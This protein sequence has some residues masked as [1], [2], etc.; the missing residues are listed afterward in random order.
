[1][2]DPEFFGPG[3]PFAGGPFGDL[4]RNLARLF[5]TQGPV[6]WEIARQMALWAATGG[7]PEGNVDPVARVRMEELIRVAEL[8]VAEATGLAVSSSG[9]LSVRA[10]T[11]SEWALRTLEAWKPQLEALATRMNSA[12]A[13]SGEIGDTGG[14][15]GGTE[16]PAGGEDPMAKLFA[17]L[18]QVLGPF[19]F[20]LQAGSMVGQLATRSMGQYDLPVPRPAS[21]ELL[22]VPAAIDS[23]ASDWS[24]EPDDARMWVCLREASHHAV[25]GRPHVRA[26]LD[27]LIGAYIAAFDPNPSFLEEKLGGLDPTDMSGM[28]DLLG[29][30]ETLLGEMESDE[31]RRVRASLRC[32]LGAVVG[33]VDHVMDS[34][35]RRLIG[36]YGP[37]T[38]ALRRRRL[39]ESSGTRILGKLFGVVLDQAGYEEGR[40]F[41]RGITERAGEEGLSRLWLSER[42]L[43]TPA[44]LSAPG[45]WLARI[46]LPDS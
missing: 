28:Q 19:L 25:L 43:P 22:V 23:F 15:A 4:M 7:E 44:E 35:G 5:T 45:L 32:I 3:G 24:I 30:P 10:V 42:E 16:G 6:N 13:Q 37:I 21:D 1:M 34:V 2:S 41:V 33:Y 39:E 18:P 27:G 36:S 20:G 8:H 46:D 31:Q 38:E 26:R 17:N 12:L 40:S 11:P 29:D 14:L 9:L